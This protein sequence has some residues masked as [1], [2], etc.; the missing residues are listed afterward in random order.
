MPVEFDRRV[1]VRRP[2]SLYLWIRQPVRPHYES[3]EP[4]YDDLLEGL[5]PDSI[6]L[7]RE[8]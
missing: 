8:W 4:R 6:V 7:R 5:I 1:T 2:V 3:I